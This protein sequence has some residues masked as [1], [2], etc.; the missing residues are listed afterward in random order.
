MEDASRYTFY[1]YGREGSWDIRIPAVIAQKMNLSY[2]PIYLEEEY[3]QT[4]PRAAHQ[5]VML[6]DGIAEFTHANI[7]YVYNHFLQPQSSLLTGLF[8]SEL[9]KT[10][11]SRGLF[12]DENMVGV[13]NAADPVPALRQLLSAVK[14]KGGEWV[15]HDKHVDEE[16]VEMISTHPF[17]NNNRPENEKFFYYLLMVGM[18]KYFR[19]ETR[20]QKPWKWNL[21]PYFDLDFVRTLLKTPYPWVYNFSQKKNLFKNLTIHRIYGEIIHQ[22]PLL[23]NIISTHGYRPR[24]LLKP[25]DLPLLAMEYFQYKKRIR[26]ES[27][28]NFQKKLALDFISQNQEFIFENP[29]KESLKIGNNPAGDSKTFL[30]MTSLRYW[31]RKIG[32]TFH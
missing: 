15:H 21:H 9:I 5:A 11:S 30:K 20:I 10:P 8:G 14:R 32:A 16:M 23:S 3:E 28:L 29:E 27:G 26:N 17:I 7:A 13:L 12:L 6:S 18:R 19:K 31:L 2:T 24:Y 1:S 4:F 22:N 25:W